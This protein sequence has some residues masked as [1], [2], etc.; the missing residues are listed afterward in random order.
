MHLCL[1]Q[2]PA[3][4]VPGPTGVPPPSG[5]PTTPAVLK[6]P[7]ISLGP[8]RAGSRR[9]LR[10]RACT[11]KARNPSQTPCSGSRSLPIQNITLVVPSNV[12]VYV[13]HDSTMSSGWC[14]PI[15]EQG[16]VVLYV[17]KV[18]GSGTKL[19]NEFPRYQSPGQGWETAWCVTCHLSEQDRVWCLD[20]G[21][22]M[23]YNEHMTCRSCS[24]R[25]V[26]MTED[27]SAYFRGQTSRSELSGASSAA[28]SR[29]SLCVQ[30]PYLTGSHCTGYG[31]V[32]TALYSYGCCPTRCIRC[33]QTQAMY[34]YTCSAWL[35]ASRL[36][37]L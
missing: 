22:R 37:P 6:Q 31:W 4:A 33:Y 8:L 12:Y 35:R 26:G 27:M 23:H 34:M 13:V 10:S 9:H 24:A 25:R 1:R 32:T 16:T 30:S 20:L 14:H 21:P 15:Q 19:C 2:R 11:V 17:C 5:R 18:P 7:C 28:G 36:W 3:R 29:T